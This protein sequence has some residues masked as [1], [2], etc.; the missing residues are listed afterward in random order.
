[1]TK[2]EDK[3]EVIDHYVDYPYPMRNPE[4]EKTRT[5]S[6]IGESLMEMNH[7]LYKG[8][9]KFDKDFNV[10]V[11]GGG[12]GDSSTYLSLISESFGGSVTYIDFSSTSMEIAKKRAEVKGLKNI[13]FIQDSIYNIPN[14]KLGKFD[15]INCTGV[16]HHLEDPDLGLKILS[17]SL[18]DDGGMHLMIY[19]AVARTGVY[20]LQEVFRL[21]NKDSSSRSEKVLNARSVLNSLPANCIYA[22]TNCLHGDP[23]NFGD[24]GIYDMF[25]HAQDRAYTVEQ[26]LEFAKKPGLYFVDFSI[27]NKE[28]MNIDICITNPD[29]QKK[30]KS[31]SSKEEQWKICE[32]LRGDVIKHDFYVS[33]QSDSIAKIEE[34]MCFISYF[35]NMFSG[36]L[37]FLEKQEQ[38]FVY[39]RLNTPFVGSRCEVWNSDFTKDLLRYLKDKAD[40][41]SFISL[42]EIR[43]E[44][45]P[46]MSWEV[47]SENLEKAFGSAIE[48]HCI[49]LASKDSAK[50]LFS[51]SQDLAQREQKRFDSYQNQTKIENQQGV[52]V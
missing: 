5:L 40:K 32:L 39:V 7:F 9:K 3:Q 37:D 21:I 17:D 18:K 29:L 13:N 15:F 31:T 30:V 12:T 50:Q 34:D 8:R 4:D 11:A 42:D 6:I 52:L 47:F 24:I 38:E 48:N 10:L 20:H 19:G 33:K 26:M 14:L 41:N 16:L 36:L 49:L 44:I 51:L 2:K 35:P 46:E 1:M 28:S 25:L 23:I 45:K 22:K 27:A 43:K